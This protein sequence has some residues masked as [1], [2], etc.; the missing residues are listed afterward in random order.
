[1]NKL[2]LI[3]SRLGT[4]PFDDDIR[5]LI[6]VAKAAKLVTTERK[7]TWYRKLSEALSELEK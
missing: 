3:E 2:E 6:A 4:S 5:K 7:L 1:M